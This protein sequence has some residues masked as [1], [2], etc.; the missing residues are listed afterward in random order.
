MVTG[1][2]LPLL[3]VCCVIPYNKNGQGPSA[4]NPAHLYSSPDRKKLVTVQQHR[5]CSFLRLKL[6]SYKNYSAFF[7]GMPHLHEAGLSDTVLQ[8]QVPPQLQK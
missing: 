7:S 1:F 8:P 2:I 4:G 5:I 6:D 3:D